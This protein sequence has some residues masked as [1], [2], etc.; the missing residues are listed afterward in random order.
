MTTLKRIPIKDGDTLPFIAMTKHLGRAEFRLCPQWKR[1]KLIRL[2]IYP[3][4]Q[5]DRSYYYEWE[6]EGKRKLFIQSYSGLDDPKVWMHTW[7][8][9]H[10]CHS[11][12][13]Y[14]PSGSTCIIFKEYSDNI[15]VGFHPKAL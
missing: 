7:C 8:K 6:G 1:G 3:V 2:S 9:D 5:E 10:K 15:S 11:M 4:Q 13:L 12:E 14:V